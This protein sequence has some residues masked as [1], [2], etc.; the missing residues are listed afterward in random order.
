MA[1][2]TVSFIR[3]AREQL[4]CYHRKKDLD[5]Q[6][7]PM[8]S[9]MIATLRV[10]M[11]PP[12]RLE[13]EMTASGVYGFRLDGARGRREL[14]AET[15]DEFQRWI[16]AFA[17]LGACAGVGVGTAVG[18]FAQAPSPT[19]GVRASPAR[20]RLSPTFF[21]PLHEM[22]V[23]DGDDAHGGGGGGSASATLVLDLCGFKLSGAEAVAYC[24]WCTDRAK[25]VKRHA[26]QYERWAKLLREPSNRRRHEPTAAADAPS[27]RRFTSGSAEQAGAQPIQG[28]GRGAGCRVQAGARSSDEETTSPVTAAHNHHHHHHPTTPP[29][30]PSSSAA[31][32]ADWRA[33]ARSAHDLAIGGVPNSLR[34][35]VWSQASGAAQLMA[36]YPTHFQDM[37]KV[38]EGLHEH[39]RN[40]I[41]I[42]LGRTFPDHP[43]FAGDEILVESG[44]HGRAAASSPASASPSLMSTPASVTSPASTF[45]GRTGASTPT[46]DD[47]D[48]SEQVSGMGAAHHRPPSSP[49]EPIGRSALRRVLLAY[50]AHNRGLGYCQ[51][52]NYVGGM[53]LLLTELREELAFFLMVKTRPTERAL[54]TKSRG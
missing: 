41:E 11:L 1:F 15:Q 42:D 47:G 29:A 38:G 44:N 40:E 54:P 23:G 7:A 6:R 50:V 13:A 45:G 17:L 4:T 20:S 26:K 10:Q 43:L 49:P 3:V 8:F 9:V 22:P 24:T 5:D 14:F 30:L 48:E 34:I 37:L 39:D 35:R 52:L 28:A 32:N 51:A 12:E 19:R 53:L 25:E 16:G 33:L 2:L 27:F 18:A 36:L 21:P 31:V 46:S